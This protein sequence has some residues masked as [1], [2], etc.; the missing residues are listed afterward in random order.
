M[1]QSSVRYLRNSLSREKGFSLLEMIVA[2]AILGISLGALYQAV[3]GATNATR[4]DEKYLY[5][6]EIAKSV[7]AD[8]SIVDPSANVS[9]VTEGGFK[10]ELLSE[11]VSAESIAKNSE[12]AL[13]KIIVNVSWDDGVKSRKVQLVSVVSGVINR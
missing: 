11:S 2:V 9:G 12:D 6:I 5:A 1:S 10:W 4:I 8:N 3:G 7:L 13:Q